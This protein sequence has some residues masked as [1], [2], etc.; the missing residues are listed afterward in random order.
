MSTS[1][2][3]Q[4]ETIMRL[5][6]DRIIHKDYEAVLDLF[7]EHVIFEFPYAPEAFAARLDGKAALQQHLDMLDTLLELHSFT[8]PLVHTSDDSPVFIAQYEGSGTILAD[9]KPYAQKYISVIEVKDDKI[10]RFQDYWNPS[11]L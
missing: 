10:V 1:S 9:G 4:A 6:T 8:K 5:F 7:D 3:A 11:A 2:S